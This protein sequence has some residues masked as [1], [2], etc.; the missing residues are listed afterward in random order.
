[1]GIG[2]KIRGRV[3]QAAGDLAG[4]ADLHRQGKRDERKADAE[5]ELREAHD[6]VSRK[7]AE[8]RALEHGREPR[9]DADPAGDGIAAEEHRRP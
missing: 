3:K 2:D 4:D 5:Q 7:A 9:A 1:M 6:Q 8:V